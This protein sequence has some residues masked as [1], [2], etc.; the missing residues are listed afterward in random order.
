MRPFVFCFSRVICII[1]D[2][3]KRIFG[4]C[5]QFNYYRRL[6]YLGVILA[7]TITELLVRKKV[8]YEIFF[9]EET[10]KKT[11]TIMKLILGAAFIV[12]TVVVGING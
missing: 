5:R 6:C 10:R 1:L 3:K 12:L 7:L 11:Y 9:S 8:K 2:G 4:K